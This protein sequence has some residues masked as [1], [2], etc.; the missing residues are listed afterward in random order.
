MTMEH[1]RPVLDSVTDQQWL[2]NLAEQVAHGR[3]TPVVI[4]A[5]RMGRV[6]A[7]RNANGG[8]RG[9][10]VGDVVRR[11]GANTPSRLE[12]AAGAWPTSFKGCS[13]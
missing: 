13:S 2:C 10:V 4:E 3:I 12:L 11:L 1:L 7:L 5:I 8:V 6:T 9:I